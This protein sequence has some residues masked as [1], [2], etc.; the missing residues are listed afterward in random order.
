MADDK[1][2]TAEM[3]SAASTQP[4]PIVTQT[5][6]QPNRDSRNFITKFICQAYKPKPRKPMGN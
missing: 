6:D 1:M 5:S 3:N 2:Q 4:A